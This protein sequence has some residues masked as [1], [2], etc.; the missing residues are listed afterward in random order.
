MPLTWAAFSRSKL[1]IKTV[2]SN[3]LITGQVAVHLAYWSKLISHSAS[4]LT[5][6]NRIRLELVVM[7]SLTILVHSR[8]FQINENLS[9]EFSI[10]KAWS[11]STVTK[12]CSGII[13]ETW[14]KMCSRKRFL[15]PN[16]RKPHWSRSE[17]SALNQCFP[18]V[19]WI[20]FSLLLTS[21]TMDRLL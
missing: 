9:A 5:S 3:W 14:I 13:I 10:T 17:R 4:P 1:W 21:N 12:A 8:R 2:I 11:T 20:L 18:Q 19:A 16:L 15:P 6:K 7:I